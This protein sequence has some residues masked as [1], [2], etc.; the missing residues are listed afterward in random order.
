M[1]SRTT[2]HLVS[3]VLGGVCL[4]VL[5]LI[6]VRPLMHEQTAAPPRETPASPDDTAATAEVK[7]LR[8]E[9]DALRAEI[10]QLRAKVA[11]LSAAPR[12]P[13]HPP[14][15]AA[16]VADDARQSEIEQLREKAATY[17]NFLLQN[18]HVDLVI[19]YETFLQESGLP[20]G[21]ASDNLYQ[22]VVQ[23]L[24]I[25]PTELMARD[26]LWR[27][28]EAASEYAELRDLTARLDALFRRGVP[29][30][31]PEYLAL[32]RDKRAQR[33]RLSDALQAA[34]PGALSHYLRF[35]RDPREDAEPL[36]DGDR[37]R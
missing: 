26:D 1:G 6:A 20:A 24:G 16:P 32:L 2:Q 22:L 5:L 15:P 30:N 13:E 4:T 19:S 34:L 18:G 23:K 11:R 35:Y 28:D 36:D 3:V 27:L 7:R 12:G 37:Q 31:D 9:A 29:G 14:T 8:S 33:D 17:E 10:A 21:P 25:S